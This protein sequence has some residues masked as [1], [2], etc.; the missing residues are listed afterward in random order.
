MCVRYRARPE[1]T[2]KLR[3]ICFD[4]I[5]MVICFGTLEIFTIFESSYLDVEVVGIVGRD[6]LSCAGTLRFFLSDF[7][8]YIRKDIEA[9]SY[10][11]LEE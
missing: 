6:L 10:K 4:M 11:K 2:F 3:F 9:K 5:L 1:S 8:A 7:I